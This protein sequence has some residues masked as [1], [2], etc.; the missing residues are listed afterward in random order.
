MRKALAF[1]ILLIVAVTAV[2]VVFVKINSHPPVS[3]CLQLIQYV[4]ANDAQKSYAL[5]TKDAQSTA[6]Y[7]S[8]KNQVKLLSVFFGGVTPKLTSDPTATSLTTKADTATE[9]YHIFY[10]ASNFDMTCGLQKNGKTFLVDNF[11]N[12]PS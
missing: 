9:K 1:A 5:F 7:N 12:I 2:V 6:D 4:E 10:N 8:W 11:T 3:A